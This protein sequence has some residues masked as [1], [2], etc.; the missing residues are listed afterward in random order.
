MSHPL[1]STSTWLGIDV[2][3]LQM[4]SLGLRLARISY[5]SMR[6]WRSDLKFC[7]GL[8]NPFSISDAFGSLLNTGDGNFLDKDFVINPCSWYTKDK[9]FASLIE[10]SLGLTYLDSVCVISCIKQC[11]FLSP[12]LLCIQV[13]VWKL[14]LS[15]G[16]LRIMFV[17]QLGTVQSHINSEDSQIGT[18]SVPYL[19]SGKSSS[20]CV[21]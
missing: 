12:V 9:Y 6:R 2:F 14:I 13:C 3:A 16:V 1:L 11:Q 5:V 8:Q 20:C 19:W 10:I 18:W 15:K 7:V 17:N 4:R 21:T